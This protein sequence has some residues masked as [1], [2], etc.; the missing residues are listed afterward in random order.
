[1]MGFVVALVPSIGVLALFWMA[2]RAMVQADRRERIAQARI[3]LAQSAGAGAQP[4]PDRPEG[5]SDGGTNHGTDS[6]SLLQ[7]G[8]P[9][10]LTSSP[11]P[12][13]DEES[14]DY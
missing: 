1:M 14:P 9:G 11:L 13:S 8:E 6:A 5:G 12:D 10:H 3:E 7:M 2:I 4:A